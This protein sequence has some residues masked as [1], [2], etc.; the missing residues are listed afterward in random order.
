MTQM[1]HYDALWITAAKILRIHVWLFLW[2]VVAGWVDVSIVGW[3]RRL[4]CDWR[5]WNLKAAR[6]TLH[7]TELLL[8]WL[9]LQR[10]E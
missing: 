4:V 3:L 2:F 5:N 7:G 6:H 10:F 1:T 8:T 9:K